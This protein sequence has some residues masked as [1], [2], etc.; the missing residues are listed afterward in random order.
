VRCSRFFFLYFFSSCVFRDDYRKVLRDRRCLEVL[1][2]HLRSPSL[3]V[4]SNACGTL[5]NLSARCPEDQAALWRLG[6]VQML[7]SLVHSKHRMIAMGSSAALKNLMAARPVGMESSVDLDGSVG[8]G[9]PVSECGSGYG[10]E[11]SGVPRLQGRKLKTTAVSVYLSTFLFAS[12]KVFIIDFHSYEQRSL[13]KVHDASNG[14]W[15]FLRFRIASGFREFE[16]VNQ[17]C[18]CTILFYC[19]V[20]GLAVFDLE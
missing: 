2:A 7:K 12:S 20:H 14:T 13:S 19:F 10:V 6:A 1:L 3:T 5:W 9:S 4:V 16:R 15:G 18:M 17:K 8:L 11:R